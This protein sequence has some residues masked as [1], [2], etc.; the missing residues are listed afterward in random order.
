MPTS[1]CTF[2]AGAGFFS[3]V[4]G[5]ATD[6]VAVVVDVVDPPVDRR[7]DCA[8]STLVDANRITIAIR[9]FI[10]IC[11]LAFYHCQSEN[12]MQKPPAQFVC[13][14]RILRVNSRAGRPR[15]ALR[16]SLRLC[17]FA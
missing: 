15:H 5:P 2:G 9:N 7:P 17:T 14:T 13:G 10:F 6:G 1:S 3:V 12:L 11:R 8:C 4:L 16:F